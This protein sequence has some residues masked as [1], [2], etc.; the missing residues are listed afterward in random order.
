MILRPPECS[1]PNRVLVAVA[2]AYLVLFT[3]T[4]RADLLTYNFPAGAPFEFSGGQA[5]S[6]SLTVQFTDITVS[7]KDAVSMVITSALGTNSGMKE[8]LDPGKALY[9]NLTDALIGTLSFSLTANTGFSQAASVAQASNSFKADGASG[10]FDLLFTYSPSTKAFVNGESQTYQVTSS[11]SGGVDVA[12]FYHA[13]AGQGFY[14]A[15]HVQNTG[16]NGQGSG[17]V[18]PGV[19]GGGPPNPPGSVPEPSTLAIAGLGALGFLGYGLRRRV[20]N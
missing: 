7:G 18:R 17:W 3:G 14:G 11:A 15:I 20:A 10:Q 19:P 16:T 4:A 2:L 8:N 6:G 13:T 1:W 12:D 9:L 5:P